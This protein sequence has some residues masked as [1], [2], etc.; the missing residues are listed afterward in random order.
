MVYQALEQLA[1][2]KNNSIF[3]SHRDVKIDQFVIQHADFKMEKLCAVGY[4]ATADGS[5]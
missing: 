5:P 2:F 1:V 3:S 4:G